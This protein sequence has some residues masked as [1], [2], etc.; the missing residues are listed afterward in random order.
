MAQQDPKIVLI[1]EAL[2]QVLAQHD[3]TKISH[4]FTDDAVLMINEK[5]LQRHD[6]IADRLIWIQ[7]HTQSV[8][9]ELHRVFFDSDEGFDHHTTEVVDLDGKRSLFKVF[10]YIQLR[11]GKIARY[12]DVTI[13]LVGDEAMAAVTSTSRRT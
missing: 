2:Q 12:E 8:K 5:V 6:Q 11:D 13:Q 1:S 4:Y 10:G 3:T 9:V 7:Q